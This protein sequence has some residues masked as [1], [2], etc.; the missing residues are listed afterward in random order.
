[1]PEARGL[2]RRGAVLRIIAEVMEEVARTTATRLLC[3]KE[4]DP[5][6]ARV[7]RIREHG[8]FRAWSLPSCSLPLVWNS[9]SDY[10][11]ALTAGYRRQ[12]RATLQA[13]AVAGLKVRLVDHFSAEG[14]TVYSLY[15]Q[16]IRRAAYRLET[17]NRSFIDRLDTDLGGRSRAIFLERAGKTLAVAVMLYSPN[18]T[19][20]L[21][22]GLDYAAPREWQ[23]YPNL[24][25]E[26]VAE[27][28]RSGTSRLEL[29]QTSYPLKSRMGAVESPRVLYLR[30]RGAAART[31]ALLAPLLFPAHEYPQRRVFRHDVSPRRAPQTPGADCVGA[32]RMIDL[33][34][35]CRVLCYRRR[36]R[37][38]DSAA[39]RRWQDRRATALARWAA[40]QLPYYRDLWRGNDL[41]D[42]WTLPTTGKRAQMANIVGATTLG[43]TWD[44]LIRFRESIDASRDYGRLFRGQYNVELSSG[45]GGAKGIHVYSRQERSVYGAMIAARNGVP[46]ELFPVRA[47][48]ILRV[49]SPGLR[50]INTRWISLAHL[51]LERP[52]SGHGPR[53]QRGRAERAGW[54]AVG[55]PGTGAGTARAGSDSAWGRVVPVAEVLEPDVRDEIAGAFGARSGSCIRR[56]KASSLAPAPRDGCT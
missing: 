23:V 25:A 12:L 39:I 21:L 18:M 31:S 10:L 15:E 45:T 5:D 8:Y 33:P 29:G 43:A 44:E 22:A 49:D 50:A 13:R 53:P 14:E 6:D 48:L 41:N 55:P 2:G 7:A 24:V 26:V 32:R 54:P 40:A 19:T 20:F 30:H 36:F 38:W 52:H 27:A 28:I 46:A 34:T 4:F 42:V 17:L 35:L 47:V 56:V 3:L 37:R 9:F 1:M 51:S 11:L 16:V